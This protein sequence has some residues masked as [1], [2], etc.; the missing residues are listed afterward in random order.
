MNTLALLVILI[1]L[2][3]CGDEPRDGESMPYDANTPVETTA[4]KKAAH[5]KTPAFA[6]YL[7]SA[8]DVT[9][10]GVAYRDLEDFYTQELGRL[11]DKARKA[12]FDDSYTF[13]LDAQVGFKDLW[14]D[15]EVYV[16]PMGKSGYQGTAK[17]KEDGMFSVSLPDAALDDV[18]RVRATKRIRII[19]KNDEE[20]KH[21][22]FNFSATEQ[23]VPYHAGE[24]PI[25]LDSF[26]TQVTAYD[27]APRE[28]SGLH[29]AGVGGGPTENSVEGES[30]KLRKGMSNAQ[31]LAILGQDQLVV[32]SSTKWCWSGSYEEPAA[33]CAVSY[34]STCGCWVTFDDS[35][36]LAEVNNIRADLID[37]VGW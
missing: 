8:F 22:C 18:Y 15:M 27:C 16:S 9:V 30:T 10:D 12:G 36:G 19:A 34:W 33:V 14:V 21:S 20:E 37:L 7:L 24:K 4:T 31:T 13:T 1:A 28:D 6:G 26:T 3:G 35:G 32:Q 29:P 2:A 25:I 17:V 5:P 23:S 11:P